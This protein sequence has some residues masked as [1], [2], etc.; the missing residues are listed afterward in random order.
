MIYDFCLDPIA[1]ENKPVCA[2]H[3]KHRVSHACASHRS[4]Q[5][6]LLSTDKILKELIPKAGGKYYM[7]E[8]PTPTFCSF[9]LSCLIRLI[10]GIKKAPN[11]PTIL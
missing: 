8:L 11:S 10:E 5:G 6:C 4:N 3:T 9:K 2:S 7:G 1:E